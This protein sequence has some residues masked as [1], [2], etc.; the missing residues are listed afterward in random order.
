M[1]TD[2]NGKIFDDRRQAKNVKVENDRR[3]PDKRKD[4]KRK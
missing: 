1:V 4:S 3:K 2:K